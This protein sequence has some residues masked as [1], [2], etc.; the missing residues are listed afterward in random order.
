[1]IRNRT[2][3]SSDMSWRFVPKKNLVPSRCT[4]NGNQK[5]VGMHASPIMMV[6]E[7]TLS[8]IGPAQNS[9]WIPLKKKYKC[10]RVGKDQFRFKKS[11]YLWMLPV[12]VVYINRRY[13]TY[14]RLNTRVLFFE[15]FE[16]IKQFGKPNHQCVITENEN[17]KKTKPNKNL[18]KLR[19]IKKAI[20]RHTIDIT[21][22]KFVFFHENNIMRNWNALWPFPTR[23]IAN[24]FRKS[25]LRYQFQ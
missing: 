17:R 14:G 15:C 3:V 7:K 20:R 4:H 22:K 16:S 10:R 24:D 2:R 21:T 18:P 19:I 25:H 23:A 8:S 5:L 1:M 6:C 9:S 11:I 12:R 13:N